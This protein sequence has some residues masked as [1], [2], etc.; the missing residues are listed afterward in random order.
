M[1]KTDLR[2]DLYSNN[3]LVSKLDKS[4]LLIAIMMCLLIA[5]FLVVDKFESLRNPKINLDYIFHTSFLIGLAL[6]MYFLIYSYF[7]RS[8][9]LVVNESGIFKK[10]LPFKK[11]KWKFLGWNSVSTAY[12]NN[13]SARGV[14]DYKIVFTLKDNNVAKVGISN[15]TATHEEIMRIVEKY[16]I[17]HK[18]GFLQD[19]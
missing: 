15:L 10:A 8:P 18:F 17:I 6:V 7:D 1:K 2:P 19:A 14:S 5:S 16:S 12:L 9:Q 3:D 13:E 4:F 11:Y